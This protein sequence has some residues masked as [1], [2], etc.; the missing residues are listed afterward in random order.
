MYMYTPTCT[1]ISIFVLGHVTTGDF[2]G[3]LGHDIHVLGSFLHRIWGLAP[4]LA[5]IISGFEDGQ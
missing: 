2:K 4:R 1:T 3:V 5:Y